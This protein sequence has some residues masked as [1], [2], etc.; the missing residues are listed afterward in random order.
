MEQST[1]IGKLAEALVQ[2][3]IKVK[4][5]AKTSENPYFKSKY[6]D[7]AE[8]I[9]GTKNELSECGLAVIQGTE[10]ATDG[11]TV[12]TLLAHTS[13]QWVKS[14]L[15]IKAGKQDPQGFGS[16]LTYARRYSYSGILNLATEDD[17]DGNVATQKTETKKKPNMTQKQWADACLKF[18]NGEITI[19]K[20]Q[21]Y[22]TLTEDQLNELNSGVKL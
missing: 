13:G 8:I 2:F 7:L 21:E 10:P 5:I 17:D 18:R 1:E 6:A 9:A 20:M 15:Y 16:A 4:P 12:I 3:Q 14:S 11:I 22:F 19:A